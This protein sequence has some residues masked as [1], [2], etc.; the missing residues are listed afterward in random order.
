MFVVFLPGCK[1]TEK[2]LVIE[3]SLNNGW[4]FSAADSNSFLPATVPGTI[5]SDLLNNGLISDPFYGCNEKDLQW[6]GEKDW[7]YQMT[8]D[9]NPEIAARRHVKL[10]RKSV[11]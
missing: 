7:V 10:D 2:R 3:Q 9:V 5:H 6:I 8:F 11:V 1:T 4:Q